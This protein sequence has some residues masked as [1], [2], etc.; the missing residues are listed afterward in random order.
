MAD[1]RSTVNYQGIR[2]GRVTY[3]IDD[4]T[5]TYDADE[6][7]GSAEVGLAVTLSD[8]NE[9]ALADDGDPVLGR[10]EAVYSDGK[11]VVTEVGHVELPGGDGATLT[12]GSQIVGDQDGSGNPGYIRAVDS[13]TAAEL[14]LGRGFIRDAS[15]TDAVGVIL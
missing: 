15:D 14:P 11:A 3:E 13:A 4:V 9:I 8:D 6:E 10:L 1:P 2:Q 12:L 5:I 7:H